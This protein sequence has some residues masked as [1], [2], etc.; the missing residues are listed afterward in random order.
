VSETAMDRIRAYALE[1]AKTPI[2]RESILAAPQVDDAPIPG[3]LE[4][5]HRSE[6][7]AVAEW[8]EERETWVLY[9]V[10]ITLDGLIQ[11]IAQAEAENRARKLHE[12]SQCD[13]LQGFCRLVL[14]EIGETK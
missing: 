3:D 10:P 8:S 12:L 4:Q 9:G 14:S 2:T 11:R 6:Q 7:Y 1:A 13:E 5:F